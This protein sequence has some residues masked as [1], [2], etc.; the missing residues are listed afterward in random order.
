MKIN[1]VATFFFLFFFE[2]QDASNE[3]PNTFLF[4]LF[5]LY[6]A[7]NNLS[8]ILYQC[9]DVVESSML[10]FRALPH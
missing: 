9:L 2:K 6:V 5:R 4:I 8:V 1:V 10:T 7:F 3:Y